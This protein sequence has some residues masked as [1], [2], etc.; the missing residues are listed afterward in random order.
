MFSCFLF[1]WYAK[2][3]K[4][5]NATMERIKYRNN[6]HHIQTRYDILGLCR[7]GLCWVGSCCVGL[8]RVEITFHSVFLEGAVRCLLS[9]R[10]LTVMG[11]PPPPPLPLPPM[12]ECC[13]SPDLMASRILSK[14]LMVFCVKFFLSTLSQSGCCS[15]KAASVAFAYCLAS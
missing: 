4:N 8:G 9:L 5:L 11:P 15:M 13:L 2:K 14:F 1:S 3:T 7:V 10:A 6:N 12:V